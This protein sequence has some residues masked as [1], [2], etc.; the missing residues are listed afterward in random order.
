MK[1]AARLTLGALLLTGACDPG[2]G[3]GDSDEL[4]EDE[5]SGG[6]LDIDE[7]PRGDA[8]PSFDADVA[9]I[10]AARCSC[11]DGGAGGLTLGDDAYD[12]LVGAPA[13]GIDMPY[14]EP[15]DVEGS[16]LVHKLR[17]TQADVGGGG[18]LMPIGGALSEAQIETIEQWIDAGAPD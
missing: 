10:L 9:P 1:R 16:Y 14:V 18:E 8:E 5:S 3:Y 11:H 4:S 6:D 12:A 13:R 15:G 17:G 7:R 2:D